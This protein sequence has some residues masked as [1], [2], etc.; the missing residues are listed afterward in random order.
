[1]KCLDKSNVTPEF[2]AKLGRKQMTTEEFNSN[3]PIVG[4][5]V[6]NGGIIVTR[7][8]NLESLKE[9]RTGKRQKITALSPRSLSRLA[10]LALSTQVRW[11]SLITLTYGQNYILDGS[12]AKY[13]LNFILTKLKRMYGPFDYLWFLEF[14][15]RGA[16]HYHILVSLPAPTT[17]QRAKFARE[18]ANIIEPQNWPYSSLRANKG[19]LVGNG[20]RFTNQAVI[21]VHSHQ[22]AWSKIRKEDGAARYVTKY[23]TKLYQK[24]VPKAYRN[25]GRFWGKA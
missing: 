4:Y 6:M 2:R 25:V 21:D 18:W 13:H 15:K 11:K 5:W 7:E 24:S 1:M 22:E 23:A 17:I 16:P 3:F 19:L 12:R 8:C 10:L 14:Q 9:L 20:D